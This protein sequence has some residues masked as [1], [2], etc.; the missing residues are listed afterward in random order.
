[1]GRAQENV[2][3]IRQQLADL[4]AEFEA[5]AEAGASAAGE[6]MQTVTVKPTKQNISVKR[7][8]LAWV[9]WWKTASGERIPAWK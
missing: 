2:E 4:E 7:V 3:A 6:S 5:E 9:P 1:M 8:A